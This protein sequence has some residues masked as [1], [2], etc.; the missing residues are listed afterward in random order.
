[1]LKVMRDTFQNLKWV[2]LAVVAAIIVGF[3]FIDMGLGGGVAGGAQEPRPFAARVNGETITVNDYY[4]EIARLEGMYR[5]MYGQQFT[6]EMVQAMGLPKQVLDSLIDKRLLGQEAARLNLTASPEEVRRKLLSLPN[7]TENGKFIGMELYTRYVT[8]PLG[9]PNAAAFE[10]ELAR[11]ITLE[12]MESALMSSLVVSPQAADLEYRRTNENAK[13]R[14][15]LVP[16]QTQLANVT[17]TP[18]EVENYYRQN[19]T[20]YAHG[21]QRQIRYLLADYAKLRAQ[22]QPTEAELRRAYDAQKE[23]YRRP[24]SAHVHHILIKSEPGATPAADAAARAKAQSI[25]QQL[26]AG[27]DFAALARAHSEDPSSAGN[28]GDMGWVDKG[29]TVEPFERAIFS[30]PL[31]T[32]SDPIRS[33]EYGYHIVKVVERRDESVRP[34]E[35]VAAELRTAVANEKARDLAREEINRI[36]ARI[37]GNKPANAAAFSAL[38]SG[39]VTSNDSGWFSRG[40][41]IT[42]IGAHEP[43]TNWAFSAKPGDVS[44]PLGTPRGIA[45]AY[46]AGTRP[47]GSSALNEIRQRVE[48]DVRL[49]KARNAARTALQQAMSGATSL[50]QVAAKAGQVPQEATVARRG[51]IPGLPGDASQ[52]VE[53][54]MASNVG[55]LKGPVVVDAGAIAFT[56]TDQKK[57]TEEELKQNRATYLDQ[58]RSQQARNLRQSLV[59][60]LRQ[61]ASIEINDE[62]TRPTTTPT[63]V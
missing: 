13:V 3:V 48:Q 50:D 18:A 46:L 15:V 38:A 37:Q 14:Y 31:N 11:E 23:R 29:Q 5:Q 53:A 57:V 19:I 16:A 7:F 42:G 47:S 36:N 51:G 12:K 26:R 1:M 45:I 25:V 17:V 6:P 56:V 24:A 52:F 10:E 27:A 63:G 28:G 2:L 41:N 61:E 33:Q 54:A 22:I 55:Q 58:L 60:R 32:I 4:R 40:E 43:L 39:N 59:Q 20:K 35:E 62:I 8:G 21:E 44:E 30:V 49:E 9:Y 34:F